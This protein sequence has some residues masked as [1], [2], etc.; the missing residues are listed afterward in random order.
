[1][2]IYILK[3]CL[4]VFLYSAS[5]QETWEDSELFK[6]QPS[7]DLDALGKKRYVG[8]WTHSFVASKWI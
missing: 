5:R 7:S 1:M 4:F 3:L 6:P 2:R 8:K